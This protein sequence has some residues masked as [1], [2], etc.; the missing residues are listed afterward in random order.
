MPE[1]QEKVLLIVWETGKEIGRKRKRMRGGRRI[2][3][4]HNGWDGNKMGATKSTDAFKNQNFVPTSFSAR[5]IL[6]VL[7]R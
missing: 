5:L 2:S 1:G 6:S 3:E 4:G 7:G